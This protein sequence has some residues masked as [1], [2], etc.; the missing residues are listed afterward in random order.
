MAYKAELPAGVTLPEGLKIDTNDER[1]KALEQLATRERWTQKALSDVLG[2]EARRVSAEHASARAAA[3]APA[4]A[5]AARAAVPE[6]FAKMSFREKMVWAF[7]N[8]KP[9]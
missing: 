6:G 3:P 1:Y 8:P 7:A 9:R 5:P 4:P 2:I